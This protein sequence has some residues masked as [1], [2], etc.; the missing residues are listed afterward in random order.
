M[1]L[2]R[3]RLP[4]ASGVFGV[5]KLKIEQKLR[6]LTRLVTSPF[7]IP[8]IIGPLVGLNLC[9]QFLTHHLKH[10]ISW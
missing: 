6:L 1:D 4:L 10:S 8:H 9:A 5:L 3:G 7:L 2:E